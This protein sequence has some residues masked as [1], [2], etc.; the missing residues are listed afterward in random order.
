MNSSLPSTKQDHTASDL[1][2]L[3]F[4]IC[5]TCLIWIRSGLPYGQ[6]TTAITDVKFNMYVLENGFKWLSGETSLWNPDFFWPNKGMAGLSD[7]HLGSLFLYSIPRF[8]GVSKF[9][10]MHIWMISGVIL[11]SCSAYAVA[12]LLKFRVI[13]SCVCALVY[14][15][16]LPIASQVGHAQLLQRWAA[17]WALLSVLPFP[18][19]AWRRIDRFLVFVIATCIQYLCNPGLA[20]G[21]VAVSGIIY[22]SGRL[23]QLRLKPVGEILQRSYTAI[24]FLCSTVFSLA[25]VYVSLRYFQ[26]KSEYSLSRSAVE[27]WDYSPVLKSLF[28]SDYSKY[29]K[30]ISYQI[31]VDGGRFEMNLFVGVVVCFLFIVGICN[32]VIFSK[33]VGF[34]LLSSICVTFLL[35]VRFGD[36]SLYIA[37]SRV[38]G[39][40]SMRAPARFWLV[41][42]LPIGLIAAQGMEFLLRNRI[43]YLRS[44]FVL[45]LIVLECLFIN[46]NSISKHDFEQPVKKLQILVKEKISQADQMGIES[47]VVAHNPNFGIFTDTD[48]MLAS[49]E[50][51]LPTLNG[52]SGF[53]L[54]GYEA[55]NTCDDL[56]RILRSVQKVNPKINKARIAVIG[57][58][59][60]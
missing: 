1:I 18:L 15:S 56:D 38:P 52:Y 11:S 16:S 36:S 40:D 51:G 17:P 37:L 14:A 42:L 12:R 34:I 45:T 2:G 20:I 30:F 13:S 9:H 6:L 3:F 32:L 53:I 39:L 59:C 50:L 55:V 28:I 47:F 48:A 41:L 23:M 8:L 25:A 54:S 21:L 35:I 22:V 49:Q 10:S 60:A 33:K 57:I 43:R 5:V 26:I 44:S 58:V 31:F 24:L 27:I 29:W 7:L 46:T 4:L 19:V